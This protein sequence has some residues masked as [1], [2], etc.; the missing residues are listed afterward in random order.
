M[1]E[2]ATHPCNGE[3]VTCKTPTDGETRQMMI[4]LGM[5]TMVFEFFKYAPLTEME[6]I[7]FQ[8]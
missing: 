5:P 2:Y 6:R 8:K 4:E 1:L 7:I 3:I